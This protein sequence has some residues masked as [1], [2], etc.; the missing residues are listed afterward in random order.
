MNPPG[1][2]SRSA[3]FQRVVRGGT[4]QDA[5]IDVRVANRS[6][7]RGSNVNAADVY[8]EDYLGEFSPKIGFR[9]AAD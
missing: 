2:G 7:V 9:C 4:Y 1:P 3:Y 5:F 6:S 8:S